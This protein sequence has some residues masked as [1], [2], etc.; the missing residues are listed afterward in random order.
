MI[1]FFQCEWFNLIT[2]FDYVIFK[3]SSVM[4]LTVYLLST[5]DNIRTNYINEKNTVCL[6]VCP[7]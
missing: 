5:N 6:S 4:F 2:W 3:D 1:L 7:F